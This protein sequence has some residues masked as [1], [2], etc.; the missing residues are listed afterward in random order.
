[1]RIPPAPGEREQT[2]GS[3]GLFRGLFRNY[4]MAN[5]F[6]RNKLVILYG[7]A[8]AGILF[9][10]KWLELRFVIMDHSFEVYIGAIALIFTG[11]G[12]WVAI[13]LIKPRTETIVIE[14]EVFLPRPAEGVVPDEKALLKFGISRREWEVLALMSEGLSNQEI[15]DRLFVSLN[16]I[17]THSSRLFEKLDARRRTQ[18]IEKAKKYGLLT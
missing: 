16:T 12:I 7:A 10:L 13:R 5:I 4:D 3:H 1:M 11:L 9:V 15:A 14:K 18:A 17:K 6:F 2:P 8:L